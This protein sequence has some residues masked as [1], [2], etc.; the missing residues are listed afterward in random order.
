M[1][2]QELALIVQDAGIAKAVLAELLKANQSRAEEIYADCRYIL[3]DKL[4][5]RLLAVRNDK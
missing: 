1:N 2:Y 5:S 3:H 4:E